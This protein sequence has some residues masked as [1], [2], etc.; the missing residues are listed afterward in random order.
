MTTQAEE[1]TTTDQGRARQVEV[2]PVRLFIY[3]LIVL[4][5]LGYGIVNTVI[6]S[7]PL[8]G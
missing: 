2:E 8:L 6:K 5:P 1:R 4:V 7:L 3:W